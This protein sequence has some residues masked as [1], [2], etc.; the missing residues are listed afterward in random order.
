MW[1]TNAFTLWY[2]SS[3]VQTWP[4]PLDFSGEKIL[5]TPSFGGEVKPSV[6]CRSMLKIPYDFRGRRDRKAS[7]VAWRGAPLE[8]KGETK[9][10]AQT[11]C[12]LRPRFFGAVGPR[13]RKTNL[14]LQCLYQLVD[15]KL[16]AATSS[17]V[18]DR[19]LHTE[20]IAAFRDLVY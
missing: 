13:I 7:Q 12:C 6:P 17:S 20:C 8:M 4:K 16:L 2:L 18:W 10:G 15:F 11:A 5:S 9:G 19:Q 1:S 3:Q 14:Q